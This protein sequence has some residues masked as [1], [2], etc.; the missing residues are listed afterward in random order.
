[1]NVTR[2][3]GGETEID[4]FFLVEISPKIRIS[5]FQMGF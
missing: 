4:F 5:K 2:G 3:G 1:M